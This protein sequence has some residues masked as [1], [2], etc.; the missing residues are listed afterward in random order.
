MLEGHARAEDLAAEA[1]VVEDEILDV[2]PDGRLR[3]QE[4]AAEELPA[5]EAQSRHGCSQRRPQGE[6][7]LLREAHVRVCGYADVPCRVLEH[8][9]RGEVGVASRLDRQVATTRRTRRATASDK[10]AAA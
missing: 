7:I 4:R 3:S 9:R 2:R 6:A 1:E 5:F 10:P 8:E